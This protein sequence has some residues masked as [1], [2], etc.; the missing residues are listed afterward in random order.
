[1]E[2]SN[3]EL[4]EEFVKFVKN[5]TS[6]SEVLKEYGGCSVY[7]PSYKTV[8]RNDDIRAKYLQMRK[9]KSKNIAMILAKEY[10]V[11]T[12][13]IYSITQDLR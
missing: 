13:Q 6:F 2:I 12:R 1:M 3:L 4:V 10:D 7:I 11:T 5:S 9:D 8:Y